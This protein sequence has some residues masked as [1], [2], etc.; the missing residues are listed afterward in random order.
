V[1]QRQR[2][3]KR[4]GPGAIP[5][6]VPSPR[7]E[8]RAEQ[9][10]IEAREQRRKDSTLR[11]YGERPESP[12]GGLPVSEFLILLGIVGIVAW[13]LFGVSDTA[14]WVGLGLCALGAFEVAIREHFS[15]YRSHAMMLAGAPAIAAGIGLL[16]LAG[17]TRNRAPLVVVVAGPLFALLYFP[18]RRRFRVARQTRVA[19]PPAP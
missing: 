6:A 16:V 19:R 2:S 11:T 3:R 12:F 9:R 7:R 17:A 4:R 5:R 10:A 18:L 15:G 13:R 1:A 14:L 8:Q